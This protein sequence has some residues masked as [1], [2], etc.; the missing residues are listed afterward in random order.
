L[1]N[2]LFVGRVQ[3]VRTAYERFNEKDFD[4]ALEHF[5]SDVE[6]MDTLQP[7]VVV[8]G[9][10]AVRRLWMTRFGHAE[11]HFMID[12]LLELDDAVVALVRFQSYTRSGASFGH[13]VSAMYRFTFRD[14]L[15][16]RLESRTLDEVPDSVRMLFNVF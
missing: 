14:D 11:A 5:D 12:E 13:E 10:D 4:A 7:G 1:G 15:V 2:D 9:R 8:M 6:L 3:I 16:V